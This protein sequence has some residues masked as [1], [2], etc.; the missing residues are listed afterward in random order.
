MVDW[1]DRTFDSK[2]YALYAVKRCKL[3][4]NGLFWVEGTQK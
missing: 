4:A 3:F 2:E 1:C